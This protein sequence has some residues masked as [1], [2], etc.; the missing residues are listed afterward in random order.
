MRSGFSVVLA[1]LLLYTPPSAAQDSRWRAHTSLRQATGLTVSDESVWTSTTGGIF[2]YIV[3]SGEISAYTASEGLHS[4]QTRAIT[5]DPVRDVV[6][7]GYRDGVLDRLDPATGVVI[8]F[9][10]IERADRFSS[11]EIN[12]IVV[13]GDS[14]YVATSFGVVVFDPVRN[15]VRDTYSQLGSISAGVPVYDLIVAPGPAGDAAL[16]VATND[17]VARAPMGAVNLKDPGVWTVETA[18]LPSLELRAIARFEGRIYVG[19]TGDLAWRRDD[20]VYQTAGLTNNGVF[21]L[22][23]A[24]DALLGVSLFDPFVVSPSGQV[25][26]VE[27]EGYQDPVALALG[28]D[29]N[30]WIGDTQGGLIAIEPPSVS[31]PTAELVHAELY[32][33]GP[34][35]NL[36]SGL[37]I[38]ADGILWAAGISEGDAGFYRFRRPDDWTNYTRRFVPE[39]E[40]ASAFERIHVDDR[41]HAW[42][43]SAGGALAEVTAS[44]EVRKWNASNSSLRPATGTDNF[45]IIGGISSDENG[46][47]WVTNRA[48][49]VP[50]HIYEP[51]GE[52]TGI[53]RIACDGFMTTGVTF[54]RIHIDSFGQKWI[55]VLDLANLRRVVGLLVLDVNGT[56]TQLDDD[57]C[58]FF[59]SEGSGGQG[60]PGTAVTSVVEDR[61]GVMW[62]GTEKGLAFMINNAIL[63][64]DRTAVPIWPQFADR[65]QGTFLL[66]GILINDLAV[67]PANRLWV[68]T[69]QG[70]KVVQQVEGGYAISDEFTSRNSPL[71][72]DNVVA[73][74]VDPT[75]GR[76]Y[77]ATDQGLI[78]YESD[79][80]AA[81]EQVQDLKVYPNPVRIED[82]SSPSIFIE[83]LVEATELRVVTLTGEVVA[84]LT[85][86]GGRARWD[87]R[88][89]RDRLV[90]SGVYLIVAVGEGGDGAAYGKVAVIR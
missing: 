13:R 53:P 32:P 85:T 47:V 55:I 21:D 48:A 17:G 40:G 3:A 33:S 52:W 15:E 75:S 86:R 25:R 60:L 18:G 67:D 39:L 14:L 31:Q 78:S 74:A 26:S 44:G 72:S 73:I 63:A 57:A 51:G 34:Y 24:P 22:E 10:D 61:D 27:I 19:T 49:P 58:R 56:P 38:D 62:I 7:I 29:G 46:S 68:A 76:V 37:E 50:M 42:A 69:D 36:F 23:I 41:G 81:S 70:V 59:A 89:V 54:D 28:P 88:D 77:M 11:R 1:L 82:G 64:R 65:S 83:G 90:P 6:W 2:R 71:F 79:A 5:Y 20:G 8:S 84:R 35:D 87:G 12:R 30:V 16:W 45:I 43:G 9:R 4:V 80:I 66:N